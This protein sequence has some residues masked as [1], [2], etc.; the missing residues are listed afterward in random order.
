MG[1]LDFTKPVRT[2]DGKKV[3]IDEV[4]ASGK[5]PISGHT[6]DDGLH[7]TWARN[8]D[9]CSTYCPCNLVQDVEEKPM[10]D[11]TKLEN[12]RTKNG[13]KV[14]IYSI[15]GFGGIYAH[16][17]YYNN[18]GWSIACWDK[19][20]GRNII[21]SDVGSNLVQVPKTVIMEICISRV[22]KISK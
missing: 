14:R 7:W 12:L 6:A 16:G 2:R 22:K 8:G 19:E 15:D 20:T 10:L 9:H 4:R 11:F 5:R 3:I 13:N 21:C 1:Q 17:A 18:D